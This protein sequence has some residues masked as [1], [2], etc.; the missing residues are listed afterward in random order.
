LEV[1]IRVG[2]GA[3]YRVPVTVFCPRTYVREFAVTAKAVDQK[4]VERVLDAVA[5]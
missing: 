4:I 2:F 3:T 5:H 1:L